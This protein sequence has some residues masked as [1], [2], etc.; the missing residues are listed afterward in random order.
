VQFVAI[1]DGA[2]LFPEFP[3]SFFCAETL[4]FGPGYVVIMQY[5]PERG[6]TVFREEV[7]AGL[8]AIFAYLLAGKS[9]FFD[10]IRRPAA[11]GAD[12]IC[13]KARHGDGKVEG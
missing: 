10:E 6:A 4:R 9:I 7:S 5:L 1:G 12:W 2:L 11:F 3:P 13:G 8:T